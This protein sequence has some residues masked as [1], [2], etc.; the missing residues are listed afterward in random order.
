M[1]VK[2]EITASHKGFHEF[3][4]CPVNSPSVRATQSCFDAH[5]LHQPNGQTKF[6]EPGAVGTYAVTLV[7]PRD[8][9]CTQCVLQ[10][11]WNTGKTHI[12][13][14]LSRDIADIFSVLRNDKN[15]RSMTRVLIMTEGR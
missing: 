4:I 1:E 14:S 7:L 12:I 5:I 13:K 11:I 8:V 3:R 9:S 2:L 15:Q 10:W 6:D